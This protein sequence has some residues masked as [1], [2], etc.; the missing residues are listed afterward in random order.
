MKAGKRI[1]AVILTAAVLLTGCGK[2]GSREEAAEKEDTAVSGEEIPAAEESAVTTLAVI[3][4]NKWQ[5]E[6]ADG[7]YWQVGIRYCEN[8]AAEEY[9]TLGIFVPAAYMDAADNGDGTYTCTVNTENDIN[10]YTAETA[11]VVIPVETPGYSAMKAPTEYVSSAVSYTDAGV[12]YVNAGCRGRDAGAPAGV[13][14]LKAAVRYIRYNEGMIPGS[15]DRIFTF[16]MSGGGAQS[17]LMGASGNS[18]LYDAYLEEIGAVPGISDAVAGSMCWCPVT[19]LDYANEAYEWNMGSTRTDLDDDMQALSDGMAAAFAEYINALELTDADGNVLLLKES[20]SG[21]YQSGSYYAYV[22]SE[23]ERSLNNFLADTTF[24]YTTGGS[25]GGGPDG[26]FGGPSGN[27]GGGPDGDFGGPDGNFGG[28]PGGDFGGPDGDFAEGQLEGGPGRDGQ[29]GLSGAE[30]QTGGYVDANGEFQDDGINRTQDDG[31][32]TESK[33]YQNVQEYMDDLNAD[34]EWILYDNAS[35]TAVIT[36]IA[37]FT[38]HCKKASKDVGAFDDLTLA[39]GE[40]ELFGYGDGKGAHFDPIMAEL[41][42][43]TEYGDAYAVDMARTDALGNTVAY[44]MNMYNPMYY[45]DRYYGGYGTTDVAKYWRIRTGINQGDTSLT[46][47]INLAL[48]LEHY[49]NVS[50]DFETVWGM[51]HTMAERTGDATGNFI[52]W[53]NAC[54]Q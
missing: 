28:G 18:E 46:T 12:V 38:A 34:G 2:S 23:I 50:V 54:L 9:E 33:T 21:I 39:Q 30:A 25:M 40:N 31:M 35:N 22:K 20:E 41:L 7:V 42:A 17:A 48:A 37:D 29:N 36:S 13:T 5:Y 26:N 24:P 53:V 8:P 16:G 32:Q 47:E 6:E 3:D 44:R 10:G 4:N 27:F 43:G 51:G 19:S 14:D 1:F 45:L 11:P 15:T 49:A 52:E